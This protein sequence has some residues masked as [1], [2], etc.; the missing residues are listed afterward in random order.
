MSEPNDRT[1]LILGAGASHPYWFPLGSQL[2]EQL[3]QST[4][5]HPDTASR[6]PPT[7]LELAK[8][9]VE[10]K[11]PSE[12]I[13]EFQKSLKQSPQLTID[14]FLE[15]R[16]DYTEIGKV[17]V[18]LAIA[19]YESRFN[20]TRRRAATGDLYQLL[21]HTV[22]PDPPNARSDIVI[23]TFNYDRSLERYFVSGLCADCNLQAEQAWAII[24]NLK[25]IHVHG[26]IQ[27][28]PSPWPMPPSDI[29]EAAKGI[30]V[31]NEATIA[32]DDD[33]HIKSLRSQIQ[34]MSKCVFLGFGYDDRNLQLLDI[35]D[36]W[37]PNSSG[38]LSNHPAPPKK[39]VYGSCYEMT[40]GDIRL[41]KSAFG[42][43]CH[44]D[45]DQKKLDAYEFLRETGIL[46]GEKK[47]S[48]VFSGG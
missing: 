44:L 3:A 46:S 19:F 43:D 1:C 29:L 5:R 25:I 35:R 34:Q 23:V 42:V 24:D 48:E 41:A 17:A 32:L 28:R 8:L 6:T 13:I 4:I 37:R 7:K 11:F 30:R 10:C 16:S 39:T 47:G 2:K 26:L 40:N 15:L 9:L 22:F 38:R 27:Q 14:R 36:D 12:Q 20:P 18:A 31:M 21:Y 45:E 33:Q